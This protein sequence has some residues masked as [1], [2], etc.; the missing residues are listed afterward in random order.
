MLT[1]PDQYFLVSLHPNTLESLL[2]NEIK[3]IEVWLLCNK[4]SVNVKKT[5]YLIFTLWRKKCDHNF[6][7]SLGGQLSQQ[8]RQQQQ[9]Q[10]QQQSLFTQV[11]EVEEKKENKYRKQNNRRYT[12]IYTIF[13]LV[14][15]SQ[16][17]KAFELAAAYLQVKKG[18]KERN[19]N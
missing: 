6:S 2:N 11:E 15:N 16:S 4:L 9:Q 18:T 17:S 12:I 8:Q 19:N 3:N 7:I 1:T 13:K 10:Q 5:T 14:F